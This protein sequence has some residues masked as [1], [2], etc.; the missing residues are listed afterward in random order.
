MQGMKHD[1]RL[2]MRRSLGV[3]LLVAGSACGGSSTNHS[4]GPTADAPIGGNA[5]ARVD[6]PIGGGADARIDA[7]IGGGP[8]APIGGGPD[9]PTGSGGPD[10]PTG[11]GGPDAPPISTICLG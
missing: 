11:S 3:L 5:D 10:A 4:D 7:P 6:A 8:D 1:V 2:G 9:A